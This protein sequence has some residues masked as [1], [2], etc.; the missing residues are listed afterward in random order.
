MAGYV[1]MLLYHGLDATGSI[2]LSTTSDAGPWTKVTLTS[3]KRVSDA[4]AEWTSLANAALPTRVWTFQTLDSGGGYGVYLS[5]SGGDG[6]IKLPPCLYWLLGFEESGFVPPYVVP[7]HYGPV[8]FHGAGL[9]R[10]GTPDVDQF[11]FGLSFPLVVEE[12]EL[13]T[14]RAARAASLHYGRALECEVDFY[15]L[16]PADP[17]ATSLWSLVRDSPLLSGHAAFWV[18]DGNASPFGEGNLD[19]A[20]VLYPIEPGSIEQD[21][22]D[23]PVW[24]RIRCTVEEAT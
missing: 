22:E 13:A 8:G 4:L 20:L 10:S 7:A 5:C 1:E 16:P 11:S 15:V 3:T 14:Y 12:S 18:S 21:S 17:E 23:D 24:I 19:G 2:E 6:W 9:F